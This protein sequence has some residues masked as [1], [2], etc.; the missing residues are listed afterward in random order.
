MDTRAVTNCIGQDIIAFAE[1][2]SANSVSIDC[3]SEIKSAVIRN[4]P[5]CAASNTDPSVINAC[6]VILAMLAQAHAGKLLRLNDGMCK[7]DNDL[8]ALASIN[9]PAGADCMVQAGSEQ[10]D[11]CWVSNNFG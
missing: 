10:I 5:T 7:A 2:L 6:K 3:F 4:M 11:T 8:P 9:I 1:C